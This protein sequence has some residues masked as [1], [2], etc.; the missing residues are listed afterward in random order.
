MN[1]HTVFAL[2]AATLYAMPL[3]AHAA[4]PT[5]DCAKSGGTVEQLVCSDE[6]L[7]ALDRKMLRVFAGR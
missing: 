5:C 6:A 1:G 4:A 3:D 7:A 2:L